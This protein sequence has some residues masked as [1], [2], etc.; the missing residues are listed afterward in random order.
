MNIKSIYD[1]SDDQYSDS[2]ENFIQNKKNIYEAEF[3]AFIERIFRRGGVESMANSL[4]FV[5]GAFVVTVD[6]KI[7]SANDEFLDLIEYERSEIYGREATN[8][9]F[10][11]DQEMVISR[12]RENNPNRYRLR[13]LNKHSKIKYTTVS[14]INITID[15][16]V[17]RLAEF[18][19]DTSVINFKNEQIIALRKTASALGSTIE[20]RDPYTVGHMS[21]TGIIAVEIAK[22]LS[23]SQINWSL[24]SGSS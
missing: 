6:G 2:D 4:P 8:V 16:V 10:H 19:D 9:V 22:A 15:G 17:Y 3:H 18:V 12:L 20:K 11:A 21:R 14:P 13:L 7:V 23:L 1:L 24:M 5:I